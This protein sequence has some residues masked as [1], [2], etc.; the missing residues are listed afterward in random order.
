MKALLSVLP[1]LL[2]AAGAVV[3]VLCGHR[4]Y[5]RH[6]LES[7]GRAASA[8]VTWATTTG[9][10]S[11]QIRV[12]YRDAKGKDWTKDFE[13][14]SSQYQAGQSVDI[15]YLPANPQ[16]AILGPREAG[17][18]GTQEA[19]GIAVGALFAFIGAGWLFAT[20]RDRTNG[21]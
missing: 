7:D 14:F 21:A 6:Q 19:V 4:I 16:I 20:F 17:A 12:V 2:L 11:N 3:V 1:W 15:V 10:K 13:V 9:A 8:I 18:T 5:D